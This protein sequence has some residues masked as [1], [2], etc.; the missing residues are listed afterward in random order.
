[1]S[2]V[3]L[4]RVIA[5]FLGATGIAGMIATSIAGSVSGPLAFGLLCIAGT[6][7]LMTLGVLN[8]PPVEID[9]LRA[10]E[11]ESRIAA[12]IEAGAPEADV[13]HIVRLARG[14]NR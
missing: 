5:L 10:E 4:L 7:V 13:R 3:K 8:P 1:M 11:L 9:P 2:R 6:I 14:L 12:M